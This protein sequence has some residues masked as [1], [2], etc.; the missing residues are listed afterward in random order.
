MFIILYYIDAS[1]SREGIFLSLPIT[2]GL[3]RLN[4]RPNLA[5]QYDLYYITSLLGTPTQCITITIT[6]VLQ[7]K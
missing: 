7:F 1:T 3:N 5:L 2:K 6:R 4:Q